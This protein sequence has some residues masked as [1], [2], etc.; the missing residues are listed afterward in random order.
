[1]KRLEIWDSMDSRGVTPVDE[2]NFS[3]MRAF[4]AGT[5]GWVCAVFVFVF[6]CAPTHAR[7]NADDDIY[8]RAH[9]MCSHDG[10]HKEHGVYLD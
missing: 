2:E 3:T 8:A 6:V 5:R 4:V 10:S 1:M 7:A 9:T